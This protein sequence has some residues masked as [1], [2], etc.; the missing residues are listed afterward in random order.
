MSPLRRTPSGTFELTQKGIS[1]IVGLVSLITTGFGIGS[2]VAAARYTLRTEL[3]RKAD[4]VVVEKQD[5][6]TKDMLRSILSVHELILHKMK[7]QRDFCTDILKAEPQI[8][9]VP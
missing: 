9:K 5:S 7:D 1:V 6:T 4:K 3:E 8:F 2:S